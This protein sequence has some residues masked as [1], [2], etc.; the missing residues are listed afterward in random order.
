MSSAVLRWVCLGLCSLVLCACA[1][2]G[3]TQASLDCTEDPSLADFSGQSWATSG[4]GTFKLRIAAASPNTPT[5]GDNSWTLE[6]SDVTGAP[7]SDVNLQVTPFMPQH[8]HGTG[9]KAIVTPSVEPGRFVVTP[10]NLWMPGLWEVRLTVEHG[11]AVDH[12][13]LNACIEG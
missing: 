13:V 3:T 12:I 10:V 9:V 2:A 11:A 7:L 5:K 4:A 6:L 8:G 1:S